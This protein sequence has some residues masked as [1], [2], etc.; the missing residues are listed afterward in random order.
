[1][2]VACISSRGRATC[3]NLTPEEFTCIS[4]D[5]DISIRQQCEHST[6]KLPDIGF[7]HYALVLM[8]LCCFSIRA[9]LRMHQTTI[10]IPREHSE[11]TFKLVLTLPGVPLFNFWDSALF[12]PCIMGYVGGY[13]H[14]ALC[15]GPQPHSTSLA[16]TTIASQLA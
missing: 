6:R 8:L 14:L 12:W 1:M 13:E 4:M 7:Q 15:R 11:H 9:E 10:S 16:H 5:E 3:G 2:V